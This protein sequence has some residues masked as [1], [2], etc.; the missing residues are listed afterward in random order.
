MKHGAKRHRRRSVSRWLTALPAFLLSVLVF[1]TAILL[2]WL[3][4]GAADPEASQTDVRQGRERT[5]LLFIHDLGDTLTGAVCI[6]TD[7]GTLTVQAVGYPAQTEVSC[8][9]TLCTLAERYEVEGTEAAQRLSAVTGETYDA[10]LRMSVSAVAAFVAYNG[11][12]VV[13]TLPEPVGIL[14][15]GEQT[16][17]SLQ[18]AD[19]LRF[20]GWLQS[21]TGQAAAHAGM[22]AAI[23]NRYLSP[24]QDL[25]VLFERFSQLCDDRVTVAQFSVIRSELEALAAA[26]TG[27]VCRATVPEGYAVGD[28]ETRRF[29]PAA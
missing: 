26:N 7:T 2:P 12:G 10:V 6:R 1:G 11:N 9:T 24:H 27:T 16:L 14:A 21:L 28:G 19:V 20:E 18:V 15:Q 22:I 25:D 5:L 3:L 23:L 4:S 13:Y 8:G 29:V 17:T